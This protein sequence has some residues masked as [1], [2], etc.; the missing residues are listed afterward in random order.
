MGSWQTMHNHH[1]NI[2]GRFNI[3]T[4]MEHLVSK[5]D[6]DFRQGHFHLGIVYYMHHI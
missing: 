5:C 6:F 1:E 2:M 4:F 3:N